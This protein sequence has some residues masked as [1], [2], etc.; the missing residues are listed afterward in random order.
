MTISDKHSLTRKDRDEYRRSYAKETVDSKLV[1]STILESDSDSDASIDWDATIKEEVT[2]TSLDQR[3]RFLTKFLTIK[4][5]QLKDIERGRR[6]LGEDKKKTEPKRS[7]RKVRFKD[8][9]FL[10]GPASQDDSHPSDSD[11]ETELI[12]SFEELVT[13]AGKSSMAKRKF[14]KGKKK[15]LLQN[16]KKNLAQ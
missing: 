2:D 14:E 3:R 5:V 7:L 10:V 13:F 11:T 16:I 9:V 12:D 8:K 6:T 1:T 15:F 4:L